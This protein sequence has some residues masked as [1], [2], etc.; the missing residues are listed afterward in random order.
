MVAWPI[1]LN[2]CCQYVATHSSIDITEGR[3]GLE[4][5][6]LR[7]QSRFRSHVPIKFAISMSTYPRCWNRYTCCTGSRDSRVCTQRICISHE[8]FF[9][10]THQKIWGQVHR[11]GE[12][13][14]LRPDISD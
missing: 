6:N 7:L 4:N 9:T 14:P 10:C 8:L 3:K 12:Q 5:P 1:S 2:L 13:A 11:Q